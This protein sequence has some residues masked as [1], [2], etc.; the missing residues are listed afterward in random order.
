MKRFARLCFIA[1]VSLFVQAPATAQQTQATTPTPAPVIHYGTPPVTVTRPAAAA[2]VTPTPA[3]LS[4]DHH[5]VNSNGNVVHS[6][7]K[8]STVPQGASAQCRDGSYSFSQHHQGTCSH[9][10]GVSQWL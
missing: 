6:P 10:G 5:Y 8:S 2:R 4:N 7:A 1:L 3:I 9:H